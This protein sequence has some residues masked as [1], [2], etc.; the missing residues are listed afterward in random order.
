[1]HPIS[2][3]HSNSKATYLTF[4]SCCT[5]RATE[6]PGLRLCTIARNCVT[7]ST[8]VLFSDRMTSPGTNRWAWACRLCLGDDD[9]TTRE[10]LRVHQGS[11]SRIKARDQSAKAEDQR[12]FICGNIG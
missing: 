2:S 1:M 4:R 5:S 6:S 9:Y 3:L 11:D 10:I 8:G 7:D 12:L